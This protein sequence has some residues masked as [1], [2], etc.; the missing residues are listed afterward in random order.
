MENVD[1]HPIEEITIEA[2]LENQDGFNED[3]M[4]YVA[5]VITNKELTFRTIKAALMGIR[6]K[7]KRVN[8]SY[9]GVNKV[10]ISF[11]DSILGFKLWR[12]GPWNIRGYLLNMHPWTGDKSAVEVDHMRMEL[13]IQMHGVPR[14]CMSRRN[15]ENMGYAFG[16]VLEGEDAWKKKTLLRGCRLTSRLKELWTVTV[17]SAGVGRLGHAKRECTYSLAMSLK[18]NKI[19]RYGPGLG[20]NRAKSLD[21]VDLDNIQ[22]KHAQQNI[23]KD[24]TSDDNSEKLENKSKARKG[25]SCNKMKGCM[26]VEGINPNQAT[27]KVT[28]EHGSREKIREKEIGMWLEIE[29]INEKDD[30]RNQELEFAMNRAK[31]RWAKMKEIRIQGSEKQN[32]DSLIKKW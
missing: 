26:E 31:A 28:E 30:D 32:E 25:E 22:I 8:I 29:E 19:L 23:S 3:T 2:E 12:D 27:N 11:E 24:T 16:K 14:N 6:E 20:V 21:V 17:I 10:L 9:V 18:D 4:N 15:A 5:K 13:W 7:P 1:A